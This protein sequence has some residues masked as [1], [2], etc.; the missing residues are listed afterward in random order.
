MIIGNTLTTP[1]LGLLIWT[2]VIFLTFF[3]L[4]YRFAWPP[5]LK[6]VHT[7]NEE[8]RSALLSAEKAREDIER[9]RADNDEIM[10]KAREERDN[11]LREAAESGEKIVETAREKARHES[12]LLIKKAREA[13]VMEKEKAIT[14]IRQEIVTLSMEVTSRILKEKLS[15]IGAQENLV[16]RYLDE[17]EA[18]KN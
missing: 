2:T 18:D 11:I 13:V 1:E 10:K 9:L 12:D 5:I 16:E 17:I 8:I 14:E 4:L 3:Y 15:D 7:R 6:A